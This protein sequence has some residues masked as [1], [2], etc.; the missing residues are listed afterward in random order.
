MDLGEFLT[1]VAVAA[2]QVFVPVLLAVLLAW[3]RPLLKQWDAKIGAE[4]GT[5]QWDFT[6]KLVWQFVQAAEQ[7]GVWDDLLATGEAKNIWVKAKLG[8]FFTANGLD[9][10]W[11]AI[12]AAIE[13]AVFGMNLDTTAVRNGGARLSR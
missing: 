10:D 5:A 13:D 3:L 6:K 7:R 12:D 4:M 11:D 1:D 8:A 2:V 9:I